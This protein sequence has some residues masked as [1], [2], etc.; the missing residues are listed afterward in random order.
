MLKKA[1]ILN[2]AEDKDFNPT[3]TYVRFDNIGN[4]MLTAGHRAIAEKFPEVVGMQQD[5]YTKDFTDKIM[6]Y[7]QTDEGKNRINHFRKEALATMALEALKTMF[8]ITDSPEEIEEYFES[9]YKRELDEI[10]KGI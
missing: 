2:I 9:M 3:D 8:K 10:N 6:E 7:L 4:G 5:E 1:E